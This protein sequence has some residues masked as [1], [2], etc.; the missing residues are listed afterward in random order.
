MTQQHQS[1]HLQNLIGAS[2]HR[3]TGYS[4]GCDSRILGTERNLSRYLLTLKLIEYFPINLF[5]ALV[6]AILR[7]SN[8]TVGLYSV[9]QKL[10]EF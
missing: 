2:G 5:L 8:S 1:N 7:D 10:L 3:R 6:V 9:V 4:D